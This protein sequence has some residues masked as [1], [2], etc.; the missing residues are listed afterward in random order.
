M[1]DFEPRELLYVSNIKTHFFIEKDT[2][3]YIYIGIK[4]H[5]SCYIFMREVFTLLLF[6]HEF[7]FTF[8]YMQDL[9]I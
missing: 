3:Q 2:I 8:L 1:I 9:I 6:L 5:I 7:S 4:D